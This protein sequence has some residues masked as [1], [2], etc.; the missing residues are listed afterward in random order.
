MTKLRFSLS[1]NAKVLPL[2]ELKKYISAIEGLQIILDGIEGIELSKDGVKI[3]KKE[4]TFAIDP[5]C[6]ELIMRTHKGNKKAKLSEIPKIV[7]KIMLHYVCFTLDT[8][9]IREISTYRLKVVYDFLRHTGLIIKKGYNMTVVAPDT[10][11]ND[12]QNAL[13]K[14]TF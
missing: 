9:Y 3:T 12:V 5:E 4:V 10:F 11:R 6:D 14:L 2:T 8:L 7:D 1:Q 13:K